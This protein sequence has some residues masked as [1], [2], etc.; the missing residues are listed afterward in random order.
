MIL[1]WIA[2]VFQLW[3][4][5]NLDF[6][7]NSNGFGNVWEPMRQKTKENKGSESWKW[8][9]LRFLISDDA[10]LFLTTAKLISNLPAFLKNPSHF[11][12]GDPE[13]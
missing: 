1:L 9:P 7:R 12:L 3:G 4:T 5:Q 13:S 11:M 10:R 6:E 8:S 2:M